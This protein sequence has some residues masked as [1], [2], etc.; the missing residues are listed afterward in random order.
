LRVHVVFVVAA[1]ELLGSAASDLANLAGSLSS[2]NAAAATRTTAILTAA[3]D[4]VSA[5]IATL[6]SGHAQT[7]QALS[8]QAAAF[9]QQFVHGLSAGAAG[10]ANAEAA[11]AKPLQALLSAVIAPLQAA[12]GRPLSGNGGNAVL[13]GN[14]GNG[15]N[16]GSLCSTA[17]P[18]GRGEALLGQGGLNG[19]P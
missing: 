16:S 18:A 6:F 7:Y 1:P 11:A 13:I 5:A 9:H 15:G 4:E 14:G 8:N 12:T 19:K 3:E 2:A 10:Y 17:V